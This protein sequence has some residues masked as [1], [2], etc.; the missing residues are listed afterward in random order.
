[1]KHFE[2][3][4]AVGALVQRA[5]A[6]GRAAPVAARTACVCG[7]SCLS[8]L[9]AARLPSL[10]ARTLSPRVPPPPPHMHAPG[11]P[12]ARCRIAP[13]A[14]GHL[15]TG[16]MLLMLNAPPSAPSAPKQDPAS[17]LSQLVALEHL[18]A[19]TLPERAK[20]A[21]LALKALYDEEIVAEELILAW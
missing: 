14:A 10:H 8:A 16:L 12:P 5:A 13:G 6:N 11:T 19:V 7:L 4:A 21:P 1:M 9:L 15:H 18:L 2:P 20:E 17:Q 3:A